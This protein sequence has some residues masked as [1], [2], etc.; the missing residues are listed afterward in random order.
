MESGGAL[1]STLH[2]LFYY[3]DGRWNTG[4]VSGSFGE[5][6]TGRGGGGGGGGGSASLISNTNRPTDPGGGSSTACNKACEPAWALPPGN[7]HQSDRMPLQSVQ[8]LLRK[9]F[10]F[11]PSRDKVRYPPGLLT[12]LKRW[13]ECDLHQTE[14]N[15]EGV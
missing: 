13:V 15:L 11:V 6:D 10:V 1:E 12:V 2:S 3:Q 5:E 9:T 4:T 8:R 7:D 14:Q